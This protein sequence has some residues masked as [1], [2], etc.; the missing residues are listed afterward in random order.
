M[1]LEMNLTL[2]SG[3]NL[4]KAYL[5]I[6]DIK[7]ILN[8]NESKKVQI[9]LNVYKDKAS[10]FSGLSEVIQFNHECS[11]QAVEIYFNESL[12]SMEG[13]TFISQCYEW[14]KSLNIYSNAI[15]VL[16]IK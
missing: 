5:K 11:G 2:S 4:P 16:D 10:R 13:K 1:A 3:I 14:L 12:L 9:T 8:I 15:S 7:H 6:I